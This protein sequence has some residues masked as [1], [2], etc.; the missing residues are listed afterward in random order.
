MKSIFYRVFNEKKKQ[1]KQKFY[2]KQNKQIRQ[3]QKKILKARKV[4]N[5]I[6]Y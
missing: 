3:I 2:K 5:S 6:D 1:I 4:L